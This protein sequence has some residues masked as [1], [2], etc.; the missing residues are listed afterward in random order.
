VNTIGYISH[1]HISFYV[2]EYLDLICIGFLI[3]IL[4]FL[5]KKY[6]EVTGIP[7]IFIKI[8]LITRDETRVK[9]LVAPKKKQKNNKISLFEQEFSNVTFYC[10]I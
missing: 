2:M 9:W 1:I 5:Y 10:R 4:N 6:S 7:G 8:K 3:Y